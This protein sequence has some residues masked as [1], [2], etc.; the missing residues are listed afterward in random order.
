MT[1]QVYVAGMPIAALAPVSGLVISHEWPATGVGGPVSADFSVLL[2]AAKRPSWLV[3]DAP[4]VIRMGGMSLLA[5]SLAEP[6]WSEGSITINAA[7]GE[8]SSTACLNT[9]QATTT[10]T[11]NTAIDAAIARGALTWTRPASIST[12]ALT[13]GDQTADLKSISDMLATYADR[14][15]KRLYVDAGRQIMQGVD[16]TTPEVFIVPHAGELAWTTA[17][18]ATRLF[19]RWQDAFGKLHTSSVGTGATEQLVDLTG[20]GPLTSSQ[21]TAILNNILARSTAGGWANGLT[22]AAEQFI[23]A[24]L[25][26]D[27]ASRVGRG[28]MARL[29]GQRDPRP[30]RLPVGYVDFVVERSEWHVDDRQIILTPRGMVARDF[31]SILADAGVKEA[32]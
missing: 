14:S 23:G 2:P 1:P 16:P 18:Q 24:P 10:T 27:I 25:L 9:D 7:S 31:A 11:P 15:G 30:D 29:L 5:G 13:T 17:A 20:N 4:A 22:L 32:A 12:T 21:V 28:L 6:D 8:G 26:S 19:G 3:K